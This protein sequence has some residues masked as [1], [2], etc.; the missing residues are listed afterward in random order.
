VVKYIPDQAKGVEEAINGAKENFEKG[1]F[2]AAL[3][4][5]K[6]IPEKVKELTTAAAA[7][8]AE[9]TKGW[10]EMSGGLPRMLAA[11]KSRLDILSQS[12][13]LPEN[14]DEA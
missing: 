1:N 9:L 10:E 3:S 2:D 6:A 5:A 8:T 14:L 11:V 13:K 4:A 7:K 12:K